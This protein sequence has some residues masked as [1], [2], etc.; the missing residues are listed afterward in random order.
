MPRL[1]VWF[2]RTALLY[3]LVG[4]TL[5]ALI[6][7][8]KGFLFLPSLWRWLPVHIEFVL[9]GWTLQFIMGIGFW[10]LPRF[11]SS[12]GDERPVWA[13]YAFINLGVLCAGLG[14]L[15][16]PSSVL[17][18]LGRLLEV[19]AVVGFAV[20]AWPRVKPLGA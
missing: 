5:G 19:M 17:I 15:F 12:R 20:N 18:P 11:T 4:F 16:A 7:A 14:P 2:V 10:I 1:S 8:N 13:A 3:L 9:I 6:L